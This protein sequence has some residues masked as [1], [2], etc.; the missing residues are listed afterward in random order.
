VNPVEMDF[1]R[2]IEKDKKK[3]IV[4]LRPPSKKEVEKARENEVF[5]KIG[6]WL[7]DNKNQHTFEVADGLMKTHESREVIAALVNELLYAKED[8]NIQLSFE[9]P[10]SRKGHGGRRGK[11]NYSKGGQRSGGGNRR[12]RDGGRP[13]RNSG[14][15][16]KRQGGKPSSGGRTSKQGRVFKDHQK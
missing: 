5:E 11:S 14:G 16:A 7:A 9:K 4:T 12:G 8:D 10:L 1:L 3:P 15:G 13:S 2:Q 6:A